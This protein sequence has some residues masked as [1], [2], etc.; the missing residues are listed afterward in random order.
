MEKVKKFKTECQ[1]ADALNM[2]N[3]PKTTAIHNLPLNLPVLIWR[4][5]P[6]GQPGY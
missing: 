1:V 2:C 4:E 6:T 5:G 3:G